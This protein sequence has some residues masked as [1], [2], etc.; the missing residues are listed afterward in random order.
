M[1]ES[2]ADKLT[3]AQAAEELDISPRRVRA[4]IDSNKLPATRF[5]ERAWMISRADLELVR[6]R[7]P[8]R[9]WP[10]KDAKPKPAKRGAAGATPADRDEQADVAMRK[11]LRKAGLP[12]D[13]QKPPERGRR[14]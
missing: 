3:V 10:A 8:G 13:Q 9:P 14:K 1:P 12:L 2:A 7:K 5:G 6:V 11:T 4:L